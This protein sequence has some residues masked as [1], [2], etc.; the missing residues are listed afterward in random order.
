MDRFKKRNGINCKK[1][2]G[3]AASVPEEIVVDWIRDSLPEI[4]HGY[5]LEDVYNFDETG[6]FYR[7]TPDRTLEYIGNECHDGK[8]SKERLTI[9]LGV[10]CTG[11]DKLQPIVIGKSKNP[12]CFKNVKSL[13][14]MY[15]SN[16]TAWMTGDICYQYFERLNERMKE[17]GR[18][19]LMLMDSCPAHPK[20]KLDG[21]GHIKFKYFPKNST[22]R[23]QPLDLGIIKNVKLHYK[24]LL[25]EKMVE[26]LDKNDNLDGFALPTVLD[27]ILSLSN[28]WHNHVKVETIRNCFSKAGIKENICQREQDSASNDIDLDMIEEDAM[29]DFPLA[30]D[31][32]EFANLRTQLAKIQEIFDFDLNDFLNADSQLATHGML[33][34]EQ[35]FQEVTRSEETDLQEIE[36]STDTDQTTNV[37]ELITQTKPVSSNQIKFACDVLENLALTSVNVPDDIFQSIYK[38]KDFAK[39]KV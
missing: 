26:H 30:S 18:N 1:L 17:E 12:R 21:L 7:C 29:I 22:S 24:N 35:I 10:N 4:L 16:R 20:E 5:S 27:A 8:K 38:L 13:P 25:V 6:L 28:V 31:E 34:D 36:I 19:I 3:E 2:S 9:G 39:S 37:P 11:T 32:D 33:S 23:L 14:V 15:E